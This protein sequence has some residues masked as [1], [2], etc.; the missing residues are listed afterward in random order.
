MVDKFDELEGFKAEMAE[1]LSKVAGPEGSVTINDEV[2]IKPKGGFKK[3]NNDTE[4]L[5]DGSDPAAVEQFALAGRMHKLRKKIHPDQ[6]EEMEAMDEAELRRRISQCET[7]IL[8]SEKGKAADD[9]LKA[10]REKLKQIN[11]PYAEVKKVQ[12]AVAEYAACLLDTRGV[13]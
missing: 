11:A 9:E 1:R 3:G 7:N 4:D 2:I 10:L 12:R 5:P 13:V 8:E 6:I